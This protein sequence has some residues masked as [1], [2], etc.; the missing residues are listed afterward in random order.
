[1]ILFP[2]PYHYFTLMRN[3]FYRSLFALHINR[4]TYIFNVC[5]NLGS[6]LVLEIYK[7][8]RIFSLVNYRREE[9]NEK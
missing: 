3:D 6:I 2:D 1:M 9:K 5:I 7:A 4:L 8:R